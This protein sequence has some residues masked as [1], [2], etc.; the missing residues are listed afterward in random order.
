MIGSAER[1]PV[2]QDGAC[3]RSDRAQSG[4]R[5]VFKTSQ[6]ETADLL[7]KED[8]LRKLA[9]QLG[10]LKAIIELLF[11]FCFSLWTKIIGIRV[12]SQKF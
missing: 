5:S 4:R 1:A 2:G 10:F 6:M 11:L 7:P 9:L 3:G 12:K 8:S